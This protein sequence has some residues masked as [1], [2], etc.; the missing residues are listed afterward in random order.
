MNESTARMMVVAALPRVKVLNRAEVRVKERI[1]SELFYVQRALSEPNEEL[2]RMNYPFASELQ[3]KHKE[4]VVALVKE[5]E[6]ASA[7]AH[8]MLHVRLRTD[9]DEEVKKVLPSSLTIGKLKALVRTVFG[10]EPVNQQIGYC[11]DESVAFLSPTTL[12]NELQTLA[13]YGVGDNS[14]IFITDRSLR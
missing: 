5:G 6:T 11:P 10:I 2:R 7:R 1:D 3:E 13:F 12:D 14:I 8:V 9:C 4:V